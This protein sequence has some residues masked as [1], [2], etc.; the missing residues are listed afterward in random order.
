MKKIVSD[1][2]INWIFAVPASLRDEFVTAEE[3]A[4]TTKIIGKLN[5]LVYFQPTSDLYFKSPGKPAG[6]YTYEVEMNRIV[7]GTIKDEI[8]ASTYPFV[9]KEGGPVELDKYFKY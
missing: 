7:D 1:Y 3:L 9:W 4:K 2:A 8:R 6:V 5:V